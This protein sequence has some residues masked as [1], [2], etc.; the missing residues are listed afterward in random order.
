MAFG[1]PNTTQGLRRRSATARLRCERSEGSILCPLATTKR[2]THS[3]ESRVRKRNSAP[4]TLSRIRNREAAGYLM[5]VYRLTAWMMVSMNFAVTGFYEVRSC[6]AIDLSELY[7]GQL[8]PEGALRELL[9]VGDLGGLDDVE[10]L[11]FEP[12][13]HPQYRPDLLVDEQ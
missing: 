10:L 3:P 11:A 8:K 2:G 6:S 9:V 12:R 4:F 7:A 1:S 13:R 5:K